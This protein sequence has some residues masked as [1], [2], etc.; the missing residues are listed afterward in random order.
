VEAIDVVTLE[1]IE[2]RDPAPSFLN[3]LHHTTRTSVIERE[4]LMTRGDRYRQTLCD[5]TA[6]NLRQLAQLSLV[7]CTAAVGSSSDRVRVV[8]ITKDVW[9]L[10]LGWA[11]SSNLGGIEQL[12]LVPTETNL[13][14]YH[15]IVLGRYDYE[16]EAQSFGLGYRIPRLA[17]QRIAIAADANV[18]VSRHTGSVEGAAGS[19]SAG[20]PLYSTR[21]EW[22]WTAGAAARD[23]I[24]RRYVNAHLAHYDAKVTPENDAI[25]WAYRT[26]RFAQAATVTRSFGW[27]NKL[28]VTTGA[29][30]NLRVN[31]AEAPPGAD[32][33]AMAEFVGRAVPVSDTRVGP[34]VQMRTYTT[35]FL[36]VLDFETLGL[37]EDFRLGHDLWLRVYPVTRALGSSR[38]FLGTYAGA[39]Y[40]LPFGDGLARLAVE[41]TVEAEKDRLSDAAVE[42]S[43]RIVTPRLGFGRLVYDGVVLNRYRN[44]SNRSSLLGGG[45]RLRG[46][47]SNFFV[48]KDLVA[49]NLEFRTRPL[50][51]LSFQLGAAAFYDVGDAADGF[52][53][54]VA[55]SSVGGGLRILFPQLDRVVLRADVGFPVGQ[56]LDPGIAP[57]AAVVS[58][59]QAFSMPSVGATS[60][61]GS[62]SPT[63]WGW[64]GQ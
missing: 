9:S 56:R 23:E 12:Q 16:P 53:R 13:G 17:G 47:P 41:S 30:M 8:V 57:I 46:Y 45:G 7:I 64:L 58:F 32:P 52:G 43:I 60:A 55:R 54:L 29:E 38:D 36:R 27:A 34:F 44:Y 31:R 3:V 5:E 42:A 48:G 35:S 10:R 18:D 20:Q 11:V 22:A 21:T 33:G 40:T 61:G 19:V 37:Q 26:R 1:V 59:E 2:P 62:A 6:R 39:Q 4:V 25:P 49:S 28:D 63:V 50:E 14:G 24:V 15:Q 51:I